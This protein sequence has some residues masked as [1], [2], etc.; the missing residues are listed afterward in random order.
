M[1][2]IRHLVF[3][4]LLITARCGNPRFSIVMQ[5]GRER[6]W[7]EGLFLLQRK[8]EE[9]QLA[10]NVQAQHLCNKC[11]SSHFRSHHLI[12][13]SAFSPPSCVCQIIRGLNIVPPLVFHHNNPPA[14]WGEGGERHVGSGHVRW[15]GGEQTVA[16]H[17]Y[18]WLP[19]NFFFSLLRT[20]AMS[21]RRTPFRTKRQR[22]E[23]S[24][25][26]QR[27]EWRFGAQGHRHKA[28]F[29]HGKKCTRHMLSWI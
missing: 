24:G 9:E 8:R 11:H 7:K 20:S 12:L 5:S 17:P 2:R 29:C 13:L 21:D 26:E 19:G 3:L 25:E 6:V 14:E 16:L 22:R 4:V 28:T 27:D 1:W 23:T 18:M 15:G 10:D